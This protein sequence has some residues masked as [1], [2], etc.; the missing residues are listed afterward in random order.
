MTWRADVKRLHLD[1]VRYYERPV[2]Q[3]MVLI[4]D[5]L[6]SVDDDYIFAC[7]W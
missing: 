5:I 2:S 3:R 6:F 4:S 1:F 7:N